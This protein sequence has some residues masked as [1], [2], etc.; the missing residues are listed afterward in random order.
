[1]IFLDSDAHCEEQLGEVVVKDDI[2]VLLIPAGQ[3]DKQAQGLRVHH[4]P[5]RLENREELQQMRCGLE[6]VSLMQLLQINHSCIK[7]VLPLQNEVTVHLSMFLR[8]I[9]AT[10]LNT[11]D[12]VHKTVVE[13]FK[14]YTTEVDQCD[15]G[16]VHATS[17]CH[18]PDWVYQH[19]KRST[20]EMIHCLN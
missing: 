16:M 10:W 7:Y 1:M 8:K 3:H 11:L 5:C 14:Q 19:I 18:L 6:S 4:C 12:G 9:D 20:F 15:S 2:Q 13:W 17:T